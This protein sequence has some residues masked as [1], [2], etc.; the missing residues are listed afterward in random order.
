MRVA[1]DGESDKLRRTG[2]MAYV[3]S[4]RVAQIDRVPAD[5]DGDLHRRLGSQHD[6]ETLPLRPSH[7]F[8]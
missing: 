3:L 1:C 6:R 7:R 4:P 2:N 5:L 8:Q